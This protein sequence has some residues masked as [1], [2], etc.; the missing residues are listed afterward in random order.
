[1]AESDIDWLSTEDT[2]R[3]LGLTTRTIYRFV[4][5]GQL[6]A[7]RFGRVFRFKASDVDAFIEE[8]RVEPGTLKHLYPD[9]VPARASDA[10]EEDSV[11]ES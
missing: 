3:R 1:M 11:P 10:D 7:Y 8:S 5:I 9:P 2:A 4:D 6:P